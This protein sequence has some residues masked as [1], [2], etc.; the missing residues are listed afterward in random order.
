LPRT[1]DHLAFQVI[2][3]DLDVAKG[4][5]C[6][7]GVEPRFKKVVEAHGIPP[8]RMVE[9]NLA[10]LLRIITEQLISL[11]AAEAIWQRIEKRLHPFEAA[12]ILSLEHE[13]L[14]SLGLTGAKTRCFHALSSA[15]HVGE[16]DFKSLEQLSDKDALKKLMA[17]KG[18]GPWTADIYL[19]TALGRAD[20]CPSGDLALQ[21]AAQD[22]FALKAKPSPEEFLQLAEAWRPWRSVAARLLWSHYRG[23]KGF[24]QAVN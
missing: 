4:V 2:S 21:M 14:K 9:N 17:L 20:A 19:L 24:S 7:V 22:L 11:K 16:L 18:V 12:N 6:L 10:S 8:A 1:S 23:L 5:N 13:E 3:S 15:V